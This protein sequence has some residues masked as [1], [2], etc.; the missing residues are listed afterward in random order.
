MDKELINEEINIYAIIVAA[1]RG[2]R[3][4]SGTP[5]QL[6]HYGSSTVL[7][8]ALERFAVRDDID[9]IILVSPQDGSLDG[10]YSEICSGAVRTSGTDKLIRIVRG[11]ESRG[12][13]VKAGLAGASD[14]AA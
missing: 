11:G 3:M 6:L 10:I 12:D 5:K 13:S 1:G 2:T 14:M 4:G 9:G 8:T 7:G